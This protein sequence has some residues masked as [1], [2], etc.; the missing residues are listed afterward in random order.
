MFVCAF[1]VVNGA[2]LILFPCLEFKSFYPGVGVAYSIHKRSMVFT[3]ASLR[4]PESWPARLSYC[5]RE[6]LLD[7]QALCEHSFVRELVPKL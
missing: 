5:V 3:I 2:R 6:A 7:M 4:R 1:L